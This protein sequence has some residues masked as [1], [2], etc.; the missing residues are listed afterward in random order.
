MTYIICVERVSEYSANLEMLGGCSD[1]MPCNAL[2]LHM[3]EKPENKRE[4]YVLVTSYLIDFL[5][6]IK[7]M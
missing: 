7:L 1:V 6:K 3:Y 5:K 2:V 4:I